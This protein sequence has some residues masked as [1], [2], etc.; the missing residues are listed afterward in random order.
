VET[1]G[2]LLAAWENFYVILGSSGGALV[3]LQ[4]VVVALIADTKRTSTKRQADALDAFGTPTILHF[5]AVL[6]VSLIMSAPWPS[7]SLAAVALGS[8]GCVGV[9]YVGI[10]IRRARRQTGY[11][12][13]MEDWMWH[14]VL[15]FIAYVAIALAAL[16][17][18]R[19]AL[20]SLFAVA[21][22]ALLLLCVG[23]HNAWDG[24]TYIAVYEPQESSH[25]VE[26]GSKESIP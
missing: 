6:L 18:G 13:V 10:V 1:T 26:P 14:M 11:Q 21:G 4:F 25:A 16:T 23:I 19:H 3:G 22:A 9:G 5:G 8:S 7:L 17:L 24:V 15:P 20:M 12:L 2:S